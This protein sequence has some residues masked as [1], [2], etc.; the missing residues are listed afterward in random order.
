[1]T[2]SVTS[3]RSGEIEIPSA[4]TVRT[5]PA[6]AVSLRTITAVVPRGSSIA[7]DTLGRSRRVVEA[8]LPDAPTND[9]VA[10]PLLSTPVTTRVRPPDV[11]QIGRASGRERVC[12]DVSIRGGAG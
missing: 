2:F 5:A 4:L 12:K 3:G 10:E 11:G 7:V 8:S 1:M 6:D 9:T